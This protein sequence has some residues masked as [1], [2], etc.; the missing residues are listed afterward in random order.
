VIKGRDGTAE[1]V[2]IEGA[3]RTVFIWDKAAIDLPRI[4][5]KIS[6]SSIDGD[7]AVMRHDDIQN[8]VVVFLDEVV[9]RT[10][11]LLPQFSGNLSQLPQLRD[12]QRNGADAGGKLGA[13]NTTYI[14]RHV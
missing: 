4:A 1:N 11:L 13:E 8:L 14:A 6:K 10:G 9:E 2:A 5:V 7:L 12:I 3:H